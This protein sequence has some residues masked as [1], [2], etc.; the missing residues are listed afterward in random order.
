MARKIAAC[1][2]ALML[3]ASVAASAAAPKKDDPA[4]KRR[5]LYVTLGENRLRFEAPTGMCFADATKNVEISIVKMTAGL[6][7]KADAGSLIAVFMPCDSLANP[8]NVMAREGRVPSF[9]IIT[10]PR[11][12]EDAA[13]RGSLED[14]L[15]YRAASFNEYIAVNL[16]AWLVAADHMRQPGDTVQPPVPQDSAARSASGVVASYSQYLSADN[17]PYPTAG[18][19]GTTLLQGH[20]VEILVRMNAASGIDTPAKAQ[21]FMKDFIDLQADLNR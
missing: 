4:T 17:Y 18:A 8:R 7:K 1:A 9:G 19:V 21:D 10:W 3:T 6:L 11:D 16:P 5:T 15:S 13:P 2:L 12:I 20:P 14:Y